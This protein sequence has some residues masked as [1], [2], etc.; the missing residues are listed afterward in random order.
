MTGTVLVLATRGSKLAL[1]QAAITSELITAAHPDVTI[2]IRTVKTTGDKDRRPFTEIGGKGLFTSEVER[3]VAEGRAHLAVHSAKDLTAAIGPGCTIAAVPP[4]ERV[5]DVIV[6]G[7][8]SAMDRLSSLPAGARV[9]TS[10][11][12]RR[13]LLA[14]ARGDL[15]CVEFR[16]NL[17][18]RLRK[19][20]EGE[21]D[22][23]L[24][25]AAGIARLGSWDD[26]DPA[27][28]DPTWWVPPPGQGALAIEARAD[29]TEVLA[30]LGAL[31]DPAA[32]ATLEVE[33]A[34]S[35]RLEGSCS[36]PLGCFAQVDGDRLVVTGYIGHPSGTNAI[37]DRISGGLRDARAIGVELAE[38]II[39]GGGDDIL[40]EL[41]GEPDR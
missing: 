5:E 38:A 14:E 3:E 4:R 15:E 26:A 29:D 6:G 18:T 19:I 36:V 9:G 16:G 23:A 30:L 21:V 24:L 35:Q 10:S 22:A 37:R 12:R 41:G 34:F 20:A 17:D 39:A 33:R 1:K 40:D 31:D 8:G 28:L 32:R 7:S 27:P 13:A 25:A 11:I 2:K